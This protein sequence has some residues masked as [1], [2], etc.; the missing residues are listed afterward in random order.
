VSACREHEKSSVTPVQRI[1]VLILPS[2]DFFTEDVPERASGR[3]GTRTSECTSLATRVNVDFIVC[4]YVRR[5]VIRL[6]W[7]NAHWQK[8][9]LV[10]YFE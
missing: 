7:P 2:I 10:Q 6:M 4:I 5:N 8:I 3:S 1:Q 9:N